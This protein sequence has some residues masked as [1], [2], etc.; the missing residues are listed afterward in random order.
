MKLGTCSIQD[1]TFG[2]AGGVVTRQVVTY[3]DLD[4]NEVTQES[5]EGFIDPHYELVDK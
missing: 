5:Y 1:C 4:G 2:T 3:Y